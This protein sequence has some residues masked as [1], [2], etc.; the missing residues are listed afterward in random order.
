MINCK[1][2]IFYIITKSPYRYDNSILPH[3][4]SSGDKEFD[5]VGFDKGLLQGWQ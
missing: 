4:S 1:Y 5:H 2:N 3:L